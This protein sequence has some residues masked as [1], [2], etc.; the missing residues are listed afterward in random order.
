MYNIEESRY[1]II[2]VS[3][4]F[5]TYSSGIQ[6]IPDMILRICV[7]FP[8]SKRKYKK[9]YFNSNGTLNFII[10]V[11]LLCYASIAQKIRT[12]FYITRQNI[13]NHFSLEM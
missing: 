9:F 6:Q 4:V 2:L 1:A 7:F 8:L 12:L 5:E 13:Y 11:L 10:P 3:D